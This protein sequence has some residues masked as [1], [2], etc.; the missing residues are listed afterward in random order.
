MGNSRAVVFVPRVR[1]QRGDVPRFIQSAEVP[2]ETGESVLHQYRVGH[3][4]VSD[5]QEPLI[6]D[7]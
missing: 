3:P 1:R 2:H 6:H 7:G 4:L 5:S